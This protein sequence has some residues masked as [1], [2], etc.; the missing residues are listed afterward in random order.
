MVYH[1][2]VIAQL[3]ARYEEGSCSDYYD[4]NIAD[5]LDSALA[6]AKQQMERRVE[7]EQK[8]IQALED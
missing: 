6:Q 2:M 7:V 4:R 5:H 1:R 3:L 8:G